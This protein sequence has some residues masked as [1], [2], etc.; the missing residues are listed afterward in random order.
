MRFTTIGVRVSPA[1][2]R[3]AGRHYLQAVEQLEYSRDEQQRNRD[4][5]HFRILV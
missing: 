5:E 4:P 1:P 3:D 2:R